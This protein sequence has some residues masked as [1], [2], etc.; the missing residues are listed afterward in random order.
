[1]VYSKHAKHVFTYDG[2]IDTKPYSMEFV[3]G[4]LDFEL[5]DDQGRYMLRDSGQGPAMD[6][7]LTLTQPSLR[8]G[9]K[10]TRGEELLADEDRREREHARPEGEDR[11]RQ[12]VE[13]APTG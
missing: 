3:L 1:M 7:A 11:K 6:A 12:D 13:R 2:P 8:R 4:L 10:R 5:P 9:S